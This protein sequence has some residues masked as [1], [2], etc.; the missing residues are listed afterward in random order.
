MSEKIASKPKQRKKQKLCFE[1]LGLSDSR[2]EILAEIGYEKPTPIQAGLIPLVLQGYDLIGQART[3][4]GK[5]A[6]FGIPI[7]EQ[8][9]AMHREQNGDGKE[10]PRRRPRAII[11]VPTR[12][13]CL[14]VH[15][16]VQRIAGDL[17]A[18]RPGEQPDDGKKKSKTADTLVK[19]VAV[20]GGKSIRWQI[21]R[22]SDGADI[23]VGTPGRI[24]DHLNRGTLRVDKI[25]SVVLDEA[26]RMLDIGFRPDIERI[27]RRLPEERQMMLLSAT[28]PPPILEISK[29][30]MHSPKLVNFSTSSLAV[31]TIDQYYFTVREDQ[32][33][34]LLIQ[35]LQREEPR[36]AII[37]C[38]TKL[39]T[40]R[41][42]RKLLKTEDFAHARAI[43]GDMSQPN[44]DKVMASFRAGQTRILVA[45]DV[46][47]RGIDVSHVSHIINFD[48]PELSDDYVH[49]V[50]RTGRMGRD[51]VAYSLVTPLQRSELM[52]IERRINRELVQDQLEGFEIPDVKEKRPSSRGRGRRY[53]RGL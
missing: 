16:E 35:L 22:L 2:L 38:R 30:Y 11:L 43:H 47:G 32:K 36:Q 52:Q 41:L 46:V 40:E 20:Y 34:D 53:R 6:A 13:L 25:Q 27:L 15:H 31:D 5:T 50:G 9:E 18:G 48:I 14:Q 26:D 7:V 42:Y 3:G 8:L 37:F 39:G 28:L 45:T 24:I 49:R 51:G 21:N 33:V 29:R 1:S 17:T 19:S 4:T 10:A 44:R 12:E 23:V